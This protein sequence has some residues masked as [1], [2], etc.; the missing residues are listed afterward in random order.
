ME[1]IIDGHL[2]IFRKNIGFQ[3]KP[4]LFFILL[5]GKQGILYERGHYCEI[6][7]W[8]TVL[9]IAHYLVSCAICGHDN[10]TIAISLNSNYELLC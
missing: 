5:L 4:E 2:E 8:N 1:N 10:N 9:W 7:L 6:V 3:N